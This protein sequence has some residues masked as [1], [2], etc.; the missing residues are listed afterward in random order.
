MCIYIY[1]YTSAGAGHG[2]TFEWIE[3]RLNIYEQSE[4][5]MSALI[6][7]RNQCLFSG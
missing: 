1:I 4:A 7:M 3:D 5:L 6:F 2:G